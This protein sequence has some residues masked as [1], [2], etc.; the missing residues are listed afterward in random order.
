M[1]HES[2]MT[3]IEMLIVLAIIAIIVA[4]AVPNL[5]E[6]RKGANEGAALGT[7]RTLATQQEL[8]KQRQ[9]GDGYG[10]LAELQ[11]AGLIDSV[12]G[13]GTKL[14]YEFVV[15]T[16]DAGLGFSIKANPQNTKAGTRTF[17]VDETGVLRFSTDGA[18]ANAGDL[19]VGN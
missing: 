7:C 9:L 2:G 17:F 19:P 4:M 5:L 3:L 8:Y 13:S 10:T 15:T 11:T 18:A 6:A 14:G 16:N 1:K 12:L